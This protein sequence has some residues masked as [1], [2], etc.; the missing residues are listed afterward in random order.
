MIKIYNNVC[1]L[2]N[3]YDYFI[4]DVWG[5]LHDGNAVYHGVLEC[6]SYLKQHHKCITLLSN[7][8]LTQQ[9]LID[10]LSELGID[11]H[12]YDFAITAGSVARSILADKSMAWAKSFANNKYYYIGPESRSHLLAGLD[13]KRTSSLHDASFILITGLDDDKNDVEMYASLFQEAV[14]LNLP[15]V[16]TNPDESFARPDGTF[17]LCAGLLSKIYERNH[18]GKVFYVG[19]PY[20]LVYDFCSQMLGIKNSDRMVTIGD[21]LETD[22]KGSIDAG[23]Q[24]VLLSTGMTRL[25]VEKLSQNKKIDIDD[26]VAYCYKVKIVPDG[27]LKK[28]VC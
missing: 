2:V 21:T 16:C 4:L 7:S 5:L 1:D 24:S 17:N 14:R 6:L 19:K 11:G 9:R 23:I 8:S 10:H 28:F 12:H 20:K 26:L 25:H 15:M 27:I 3:L 13:Y 18:G 22:V